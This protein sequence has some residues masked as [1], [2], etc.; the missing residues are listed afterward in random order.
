M[1]SHEH[2]FRSPK[3]NQESRDIDTGLVV[4]NRSHCFHKTLQRIETQS[5]PDNFL[6][7]VYRSDL[8]ID[9]FPITDRNELTNKWLLGSHYLSYILA[10]SFYLLRQYFQKEILVV[11]FLLKNK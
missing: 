4:H 6:S 10:Y 2:S 3:H 1:E 8:Q 7:K 5:F 9:A 11:Y